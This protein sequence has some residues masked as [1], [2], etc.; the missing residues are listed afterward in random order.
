MEPRFGTDFSNVRVHETPDLANAIQAQA[1][2]HGQDIYFNSGK[3]NPESSGGKELLAHE[4]THVVQQKK[5]LVK[6]KKK[7]SSKEEQATNIYDDAE[8]RRLTHA[9]ANLI[10]L[11]AAKA[12]ATIQGWG[13]LRSLHNS[14]STLNPESYS[15]LTQRVRKIQRKLKKSYESLYINFLNTESLSTKKNIHFSRKRPSY[16]HNISLA[17]HEIAQKEIA[18]QLNSGYFPQFFKEMQTLHKGL[19]SELIDLEIIMSRYSSVN[20]KPKPHVYKLKTLIGIEKD[21]P[22]MSR[23]SP[24]RVGASVRAF[25]VSYQNDIGMSWKITVIVPALK[26]GIGF[27]GPSTG[28]PLDIESSFGSDFINAGIAQEYKYYPPGYFNAQMV[29]GLS[30]EA[31]AGYGESISGLSFGDVDFDTSTSGLGFNFKVPSSYG[32]AEVNTTQGLSTVVSLPYNKTGLKKPEK[33]NLE[34]PTDV[35]QPFIGTRIYFKSGDF[36]LDQE[37]DQCLEK[38]IVAMLHHEKIFPGDIFHINIEGAASSDW[39]TPRASSRQKGLS[40]RENISEKNSSTEEEQIALNLNIDLAKKRA[41]MVKEEFLLKLISH[42]DQFT[43]GVLESSKV[44]ANQYKVINPDSS[45][46]GPNS[47]L[48]RYVN[49][50]VRYQTS[51]KNNQNMLIQ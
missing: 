47:P 34:E 49:L 28:L 10:N 39:K 51:L 31:S 19:S 7:E 27:S 2:T 23:F 32:Q 25:E 9:Q 20:I 38:V 14:N 48:H 11:F 40:F 21:T 4:L 15:K 44:F 29:S 18:R 5:D 50:Q 8:Y 13:E 26:I 17:E 35:W 1:F 45:Y 42:K 16:D 37:D 6:M 22:L 30:A 24:S 46:D 33:K 36:I 12:H 41:R 43:L 3:Y